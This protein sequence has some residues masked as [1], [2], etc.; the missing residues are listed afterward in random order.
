MADVIVIGADRQFSQDA[1]SVMVNCR[2]EGA[3]QGDF[4]LMVPPDYDGEE[5][6]GRIAFAAGIGFWPSTVTFRFKARCARYSR[7]LAT[8]PASPT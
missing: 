2:I 8:T 6:K 3:F 4:A 5:F 7:S 1:K